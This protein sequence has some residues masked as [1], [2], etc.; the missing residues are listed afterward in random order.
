[1][2]CSVILIFWSLAFAIASISANPI[3]ENNDKKKSL[4][5][6]IF[7]NLKDLKTGVLNIICPEV[8]QDISNNQHQHKHK[9]SKHPGQF[10]A[11]P[12]FVLP[13]TQA[14]KKMKNQE[15]IDDVTK[16]SIYRE[17]VVKKQQHYKKAR[18]TDNAASN[19]II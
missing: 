17:D 12:G 3:T 11:N 5:G 16:T 8:K 4:I 14:P 18:K 7:N 2:K 6:N 15:Y 9:P 19:S 1:M 13:T 10:S